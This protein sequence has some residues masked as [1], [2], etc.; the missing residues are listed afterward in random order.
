MHMSECARINR[1]Q[2]IPC[3][4]HMGARYNNLGKIDILSHAIPKKKKKT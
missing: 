2:D 1:I 3:I 4:M